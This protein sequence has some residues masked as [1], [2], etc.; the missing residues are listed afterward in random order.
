[1]EFFKNIKFNLVY[2][3]LFILYSIIVTLLFSDKG[4]VFWFS[5]LFTLFAFV[6]QFVLAN[7]L[8]NKNESS[9]FN[10]LPLL[11][12]SNIYL[13]IQIIV[14]ILL[15]FD[16]VILE[17][18]IIIQSAILG[19]FIIISLLLSQAKDHIESVEEDTKNRTLFLTELKKEVGILSNKVDDGLKDDFDEL[20]EV[21]RFSN[22]MS[23]E[24]VSYLEEE[25][26]SILIQLKDE[27]NKNN[28]ESILKLLSKLKDII[29][30]R[31][32]LLKK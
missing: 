3:V 9:S 7:Y 21:V 16:I 31:D 26:L 15:M 23:N 24:N 32:I 17:Y 28:K 6:V 22:P 25:I 19:I 18:S 30:E 5:Y 8:I 4:Y 1:M 14:S 20:F 12:I 11:V 27:I 13:I 29:V 10:S 2:L